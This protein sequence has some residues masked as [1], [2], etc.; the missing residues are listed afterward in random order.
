MPR[1][2]PLIPFSPRRPKDAPSLNPEQ[3]SIAHLDECLRQADR[4]AAAAL[5]ERDKTRLELSKANARLGGR[6]HKR[7]P[8]ES[9]L[10]I[11]A[12]PPR[13]PLPLQ[14]GAEAPLDYGS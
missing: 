10:P 13:G 4:V 7:K 11:P 14:G 8:P 1:P 6:N 5:R 9:G 2:D 3:V 12:I